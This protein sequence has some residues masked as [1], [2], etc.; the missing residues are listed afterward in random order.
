MICAKCGG[1][2]TEDLAFTCPVEGDGKHIPQTAV[3]A[4]AAGAVASDNG[5]WF[6][7]DTA[8]KL[9]DTGLNIG[10]DAWK[11]THKKVAEVSES[12][13]EVVS[14]KVEAAADMLPDTS[15]VES[16]GEFVQNLGAGIIEGAGTAASTA[17]EVGGAVVEGAGAV[18]GG[19]AEAAG[20]I[21]SG[22]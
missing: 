7:A 10:L 9:L 21:L 19:I 11:A 12:V 2:Y 3:P 13:S 17:L 1:A 20:D 18:V 4:V 5:S 8:T 6:S 22:L 15:T 14:A 16:A